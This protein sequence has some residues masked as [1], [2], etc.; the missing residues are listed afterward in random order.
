[1]TLAPDLLAALDKGLTDGDKSRPD[2][3]RRILTAYLKKGG[4]LPKG[5]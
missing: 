4:F 1:L 2:A 5:E 3:I